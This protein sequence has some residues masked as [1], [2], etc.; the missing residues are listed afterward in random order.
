MC[1]RIALLRILVGVLVLI[2]MLLARIVIVR[3]V[4][5]PTRGVIIVMTIRTSRRCSVERL[6]VMMV[7]VSASAPR[8]CAMIVVII[9][10][11]RLSH[12]TAGWKRI[13]MRRRSRPTRPSRLR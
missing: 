9:P 3:H 2:S 5:T 7:I 13:E 11:V 12:C 10:K 6:I 8:R 4:T 1:M